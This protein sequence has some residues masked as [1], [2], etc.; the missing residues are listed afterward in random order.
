MLAQ[1]ILFLFLT[2]Y[3]DNVVSGP[4]GPGKPLWFLFLP[5]YWGF[6]SKNNQDS[7]HDTDY[8]DPS[9]DQDVQNEKTE[10]L[11]Q[12]SANPNIAMRILGLEKIYR[13]NPFYTTSK[14]LKAVNR[15]YLTVKN[16]ECFCFLGHNVSIK[17]NFKIIFK[18]NFKIISKRFLK[19]I[20]K[21]FQK[22]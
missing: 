13:Q 4:N 12:N 20:S 6:H 19:T 11:R 15:L 2:W 18:N 16:G 21:K 1:I 14:D 5:S 7:I 22:S 3:L 17:N 10:T 9:I 8:E